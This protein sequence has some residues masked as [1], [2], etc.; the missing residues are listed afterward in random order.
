[1]GVFSS[2]SPASCSLWSPHPIP[3]SCPNHTKIHGYPLVNVGFR[4][5]DPRSGR[6]GIQLKGQRKDGFLDTMA[7]RFD[8][9]WF[10][11]KR[12][13]RPEEGCGF[14]TWVNTLKPLKS[15]P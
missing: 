9:R 14:D 7:P 11:L 1:M 13:L 2:K 15:L 5:S 8:Y 12:A 6:L 4:W 3:N 10:E